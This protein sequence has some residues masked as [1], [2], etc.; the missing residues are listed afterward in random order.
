M[1]DVEPVSA[2]PSVP[3][4]GGDGGDTESATPDLYHNDAPIE[5]DFQNGELDDLEGHD[6]GLDD[7]YFSEEPDLADGPPDELCD[8]SAQLSQS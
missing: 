7:Y 3:I 6:Y 4:A 8:L 1:Q 5:F 2:E